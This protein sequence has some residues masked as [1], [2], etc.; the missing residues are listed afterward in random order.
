MGGNSNFR[1]WGTIRKTVVRS[2]AVARWLFPGCGKLAAGCV[3]ATTACASGGVSAVSEG[4][5]R[6]D[7]GRM[8]RETVVAGIDRIVRRHA[9]KVDREDERARDFL[10]ELAWI[11]RDVSAEEEVFGVTD[12][13]N[14]IVIYGR[15][16]GVG[17]LDAEASIFRVTWELQNEVAS[18][19]N[20]E[21]HSG[22]IPESVIEWFRPVFSD[23]EMEIGTGLDR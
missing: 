19:T 22:R 11:S 2:R 17:G 6:E 18:V 10:Y 3:V 15:L 13:R 4:V 21:W 12:A 14:R 23:L 7:M 1:A 20:P 16:S 9:L 8:T 5:W